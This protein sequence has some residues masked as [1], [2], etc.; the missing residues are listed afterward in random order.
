MVSFDVRL[1]R[2]VFGIMSLNHYKTTILED[3][4]IEEI[5]AHINTIIEENLG[6][7]MCFTIGEST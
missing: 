7:Q 6:M 3:E 4:L 2:T 5:L 1:P